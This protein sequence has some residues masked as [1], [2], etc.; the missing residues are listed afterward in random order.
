[1]VRDPSNE[2]QAVRTDPGEVAADAADELEAAESSRPDNTRQAAEEG[3]DPTATDGLE[4]ELENL[5]GAARALDD[6]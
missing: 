1:M 5:E 4:A 2:E 6:D 3:R